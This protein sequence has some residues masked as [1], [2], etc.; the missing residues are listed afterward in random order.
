MT[1]WQRLEKDFKQIEDPFKDMRADWSDQPGLRNQWRIAAGLDGFAKRS[2]GL[3]A[4]QDDMITSI[5]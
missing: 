2:T 1:D 3:R 5:L 4:I